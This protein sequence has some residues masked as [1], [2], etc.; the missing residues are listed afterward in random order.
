M[1]RWIHRVT[2]IANSSKPNAGLELR[3]ARI[4]P[5]QEF[6]AVILEPHGDLEP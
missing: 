1:T 4:R 2:T 3:E 6:L 5:V